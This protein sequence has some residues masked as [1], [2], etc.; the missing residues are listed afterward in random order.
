MAFWSIFWLVLTGVTAWAFLADVVGAVRYRHHL[1]GVRSLTELL[2][3]AAF[4]IR[5]AFDLGSL[6]N[7]PQ[8][9]TMLVAADWCSAVLFSAGTLWEVL[10]TSR[11]EFRTELAN[12]GITRK[13]LWMFRSA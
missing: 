9:G 8:K 3:C 2:V 6:G 4:A 7:I 13:K 10:L 5:Y 1:L 11:P 12:R